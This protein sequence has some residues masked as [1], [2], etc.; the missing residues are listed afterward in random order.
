MCSNILDWLKI[1]KTIV[2]LFVFFQ[3]TRQIYLLKNMIKFLFEGVFHCD[4]VPCWAQS[5]IYPP[6]GSE[7]IYA[8]VTK[9][10]ESIILLKLRK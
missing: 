9:W 6:K 10:T 3:N 5:K 2:K 4:N 1:C 7:M 8:A